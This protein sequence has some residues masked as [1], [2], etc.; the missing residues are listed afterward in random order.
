MSAPSSLAA[1]VDRLAERHSVPVAHVRAVVDVESGG[2][3]F[4]EVTDR[5]GRKLLWPLCR[6]E[7]HL[8]YRFLSGDQRD[9]AVRQGLA[10]SKTEAKGGIKNPKSQQARYDL[11]RRACE[12]DE[13]AATAACSWGVGQ[14]LGSHWRVFGLKSPQDILAKATAGLEGQ[15][16]LIFDYCAAFGLVDELQ[17]GDWT[18][19]AR[20]YNG[21]AYRQN[22]YDT[23]LAAAAEKY[24]ADTPE[25]SAGMLRMGSSGAR[26]RE[27]QRLLNRTG[28]R[29]KVDGDFGPNVKRAVVAYQKAHKA[30]ADGV[31]G[32]ETWSHLEKHLQGE[33]EN[34]TSTPVAEL[35]NV[36]K[37]ATATAAAVTL[38]QAK[39]QLEAA[40]AQVG[41]LAGK[42]AGIPSLAN[43]AEVLA[44]GLVAVAGLVGVAALAYAG[45]EWLK[46]RRTYEGVAA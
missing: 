28:A 5:F 23:K 20:G 17:R 30:K 40:A 31:V 16:E 10:S 32:P 34:L 22:K 15:L 38:G 42:V 24:G 8:F 9:R 7:G 3:A 37:V 13:D 43:A 33:R 41:G 6:F 1:I 11:W 4:T 27:L 2:K 14:V 35:P 36:G 46:S 19:F 21:P 12:I 25:V 29:L 26:V 18:A 44:S 39:E 45:Y